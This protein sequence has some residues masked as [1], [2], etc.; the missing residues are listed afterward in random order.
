M[1][2]GY[3]QGTEGALNGQIWTEIEETHEVESYFVIIYKEN[4][5]VGMHIIYQE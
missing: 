3:S 5:M 4:G 1:R 2:I